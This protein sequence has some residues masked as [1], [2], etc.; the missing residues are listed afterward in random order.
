MRL[1][2]RMMRRERTARAGETHRAA[3]RPAGGGGGDEQRQVF[4]NR[5]DRALHLQTSQLLA[6]DVGDQ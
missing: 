2:L 5:V 1:A 6:A 4:T 3:G